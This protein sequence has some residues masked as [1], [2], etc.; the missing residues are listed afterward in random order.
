MKKILVSTLFIVMACVSAMAQNTILNNPDNKAYFGIR[1][2]GEI[3]CPGNI[4]AEN[5][6]VSIFK[7]VST[8]AARSQ[9]S[10]FPVL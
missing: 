5:V 10:E 4:S 1:V 8:D 2:G 6:G 3:T 9:S 7:N